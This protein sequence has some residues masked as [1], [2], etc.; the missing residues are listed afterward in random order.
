MTLADHRSTGGEPP[1]W[2]GGH[3]VDYIAAGRD[4]STTVAVFRLAG[5]GRLGPEA[6]L[7]GSPE[8]PDP[9]MIDEDRIRGVT[10]PAD[11]DLLDVLGGLERLQPGF[12]LG[13][14]SMDPLYHGLD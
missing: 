1:Y 4:P 6:L 11:R 14:N 9:E 13:A 7:T 8:S 3:E 10:A 5:R 12:S 2:A